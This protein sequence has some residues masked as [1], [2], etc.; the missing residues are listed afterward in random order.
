MG[1]HIL[2]GGFMTLRIVGI[3]EYVVN[4]LSQSSIH[5]LERIRGSASCSR[6]E[7]K[8]RP[9]HQGLQRAPSSREELPSAF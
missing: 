1:N 4:I 8:G 7:T 9:Q 2:S 5:H 3:R 6:Q